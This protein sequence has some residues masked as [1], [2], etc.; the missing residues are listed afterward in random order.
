MRTY[1]HTSVLGTHSGTGRAQDAKGWYA[2]LKAWWAAHTAMR[3]EAPRDTL[4]A[5]WDAKREALTPVCAEAAA[6][7][8]AA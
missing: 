6:E 5:R 7:M 8:A 3:H 1:R 2:H 4:T